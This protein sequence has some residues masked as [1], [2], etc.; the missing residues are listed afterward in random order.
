MIP[1]R[2]SAWAHVLFSAYLRRLLARHFHALRLLGPVP[3]P[4]GDRPVVLLPNHST[5][6]DGFFVYVL[7]QL[8]FHRTLHLMMLADQLAHFPFFRRVGAFGIRPGERRSVIDTIAY[9][10]RLLEGPDTLLCV[11]PQGVLLP[12]ATRPLGFQ[13]GIERI[14]SRYGG[15]A[16]LIPL[17]MRAELLG[18]QHP[19]VFFLFGAPLPYDG[20]TVPESADLEQ[21]EE[22]L[23]AELD[24]GIL[25]G[26]SGRIILSGRLG[27]D[28]RWRRGRWC[29][30]S[31]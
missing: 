6:W 17:G 14:L 21:K 10:S 1:A 23:L 2:H 9:S 24:A 7:N 18:A 13:P 26:R 15:P 8:L 19:E 28:E 29:S 12:Y 16:T 27:V 11:F 4:P 30:P 20:S 22:S 25:E 5:W 3:E 31:R